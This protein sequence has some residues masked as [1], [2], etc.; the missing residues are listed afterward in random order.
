MK[1]FVRNSQNVAL[2]SFTREHLINLRRTR[3]LTKKTLENKAHMF[4]TNTVNHHQSL[5][6][7]KTIDM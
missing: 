5:E 6:T 7:T 2:F 1:G 4:C 3:K